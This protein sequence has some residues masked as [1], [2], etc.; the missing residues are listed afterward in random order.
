MAVAGS[1]KKHFWGF[2]VACR[3]IAIDTQ[4]VHP[5][6]NSYTDVLSRIQ[7]TQ[8]LDSQLFKFRM[9]THNLDIIPKSL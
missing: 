2:L 1:K 8:K 5:K 7:S 9:Q 4:H 6:H 3:D